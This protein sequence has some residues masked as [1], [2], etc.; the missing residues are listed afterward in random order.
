MKSITGDGGP[1]WVSLECPPEL[2][3]PA[4]TPSPLPEADVDMK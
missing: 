4:L 3:A 1:A 2:D